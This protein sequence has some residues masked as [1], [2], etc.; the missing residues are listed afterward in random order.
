[1]SYDRTSFIVK[2]NLRLAGEPVRI[3]SKILL[4]RLLTDDM[5]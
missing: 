4:R 2:C 1:M 5:I 3:S